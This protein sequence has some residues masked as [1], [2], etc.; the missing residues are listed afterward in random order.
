MYSLPPYVFMALHS[1]GLHSYGLYSD[2]H[3]PASLC[4]P[5]LPRRSRRSTTPVHGR[6]CRHAAEETWINDAAQRSYSRGLTVLAIVHIRRS[7]TPVHGG[8]CRH[9]AEETCPRI[10]NP[11]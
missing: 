8:V 2:G 11:P 10:V 1:Y 9:A 6:V 4:I 5:C 3:A 7:T